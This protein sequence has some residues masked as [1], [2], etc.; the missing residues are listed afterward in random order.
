MRVYYDRDADV[1]L[2]KGKR[3]A[4]IGYGSQGSNSDRGRGRNHSHE[5][6]EQRA[7]RRT[8]HSAQ[9]S[10]AITRIPQACG[11]SKGSTAVENVL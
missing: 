10:C 2:I 3:V 11:Q 5:A 7:L 4:I 1:N 8:N 9:D 6:L